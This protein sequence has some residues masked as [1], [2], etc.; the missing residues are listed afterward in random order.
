MTVLQ[1][2]TM[3]GLALPHSVLRHLSEQVRSSMAGG[4]SGKGTMEVLHGDEVTVVSGWGQ[5]GAA[6]DVATMYEDVMAVFGLLV[7]HKVELS[8][9]E[10]AWY[11]RMAHAALPHLHSVNAVASMIITLGNYSVPPGELP[12]DVTVTMLC[13]TTWKYSTDGSIPLRG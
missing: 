1:L 10:V 2:S 4:G 5:A 13:H 12:G 3:M 7:Y 11:H 8:E 9:K 6:G